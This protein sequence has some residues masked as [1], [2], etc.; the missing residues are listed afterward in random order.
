MSPDSA[1][2]L[3]LTFDFRVPED[4]RFESFLIAGNEQVCRR[5]GE[6]S[7]A[8]PSMLYLWGEPGVG[9]TH[10]LN[11]A[12]DAFGRSGGTAILVD[13]AQRHYLAPDMLQGLTGVGLV[14]VDEL[15]AFAGEPAW[16]ESLF[17]LYNQLQGGSHVLFAASVSPLQLDIRLPDLRSRL[18][19][20]ESYRVPGLPVTELGGWLRKTA[21]RRG[22]DLTPEVCDYILN[23]APRDLRSLARILARL[24]AASLSEQRM[25]TQPFVRQVMEW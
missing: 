12:C 24:D 9:K 5:L 6:L 4:Q 21:R 2:A 20:C 14:C 22:F 13:G 3:Q 1:G 11:A 19:A 18:A 16:E 23:R 8:E 7:A 17:H 25:V 15:G 10:L